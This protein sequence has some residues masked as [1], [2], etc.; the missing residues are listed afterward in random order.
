MA[1]QGGARPDPI[2]VSGQASGRPG[3]GGA[4]R[5]AGEGG[6]GRGYVRLTR[7]RFE[8]ATAGE[9][10]GLARALVAALRRLPGYRGCHP[11]V[12]RAAG[13]LVVVSLWDSAAHAGFGREALG[14]TLARGLAL[15]VRLEPPEVYEVV[16]DA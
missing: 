11:A 6:G 15:G 1:A 12:D 16:A 4:G 3:G 13:T 5:P 7:G 10:P 2:E 8:P 14:D 9:L